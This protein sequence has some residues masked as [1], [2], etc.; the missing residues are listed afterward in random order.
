MI[1]P[2]K[3]TK[4]QLTR[5]QKLRKERRIGYLPVSIDVMAGY[6]SKP[7]GY[8]TVDKFPE[9]AL[10]VSAHYNEITQT[11]NFLYA[12]ENFPSIKEGDMPPILEA[13]YTVHNPKP[14]KGIKK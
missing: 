12:H 10:F 9:D 3:S 6:L 14:I 1:K 2:T 11:V 5:E 8:I 7:N 4:K 13:I